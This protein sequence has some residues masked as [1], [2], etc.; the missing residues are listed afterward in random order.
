MAFISLILTDGKGMEKL[1]SKKERIEFLS[2]FPAIL[3]LFQK[4]GPLLVQQPDVIS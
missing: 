4:N 1:L 3:P 2:G